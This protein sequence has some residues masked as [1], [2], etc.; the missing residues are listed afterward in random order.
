M[1]ERACMHARV[2]LFVSTLFPPLCLCGGIKPSLSSQVM[3]KH[4]AA[5]GKAHVLKDATNRN[6]KARVGQKRLFEKICTQART[7]SK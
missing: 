3:T 6:S 5:P 7:M 1:Q 2:Y 4:K